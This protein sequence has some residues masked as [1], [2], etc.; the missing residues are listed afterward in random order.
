[1]TDEKKI[2][3][4]VE[5]AENYKELYANG[6]FGSLNPNEGH[7]M[8]YLDVVVPKMT[9]DNRMHTESVVRKLIADVHVSP[10]VYKTIAIWMIKNVEDYE[11]KFG[12]IQKVEPPK[13]DDKN[14]NDWWNSV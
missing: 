10:Y 12:T 4:S 1:M 5:K 11:R 6:V 8:Y 3:A 14:G 9:D 7:L 2:K 13:K